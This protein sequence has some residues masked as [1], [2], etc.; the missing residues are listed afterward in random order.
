MSFD[1]YFL[2][3]VLVRMSLDA[4]APTGIFVWCLGVVPCYGTRI[5]SILISTLLFIFNS[6]PRNPISPELQWHHFAILPFRYLGT[7]GIHWHCVCIVVEIRFFF[8]EGCRSPR[9]R[10]NLGHDILQWISFV[11]LRKTVY[12]LQKENHRAPRARILERTRPTGEAAL[13]ASCEF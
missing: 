12:A 11:S 8:R 13:F 7:D 2:L 9:V 3:L 6:G 1:G 10:H 4:T 5:G